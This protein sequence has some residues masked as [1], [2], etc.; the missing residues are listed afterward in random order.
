ME[1]RPEEI[2]RTKN[3]PLALFYQSIRAE[4]TKKDYDTKLRKLMCEFLGPILKGDPDLLHQQS[5]LPQTKRRVLKK[6]FLDADYD[7][8]LIEFVQMAKKDPDWAEDLM[9]TL[10]E[11]F[12]QR[13]RLQKDDP[14]YINPTSLKNYFVPVQK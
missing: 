1:I 14:G 3:D 10:A 8:R 12:A 11:K 5:T 9:L 4:A 6:N 7:I 13:T 2:T